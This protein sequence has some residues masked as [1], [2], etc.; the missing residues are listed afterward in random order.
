M[1]K[2]MSYSGVS[3]EITAGVLGDNSADVTAVLANAQGALELLP[4]QFY[5]NHWLEL[6]RD[7]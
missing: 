1:Y 4:T 3:S 7:G 5:G 2:G 6:K